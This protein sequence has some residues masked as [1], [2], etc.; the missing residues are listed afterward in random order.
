MPAQEK[1]RVLVADDITET[2]EN[3]KRLLQF[4]NLIEV[5]G[6]ARNGAEAIELSVQ[7]KPDVIIMDINMPDMDGISATEAIRK[8]VPYAQVIILSVQS[9]ASYMRR[10]ML[11]GA[12]DFLTKPPSIDELTAAIRRAG[13]VAAEERSKL[14]QTVSVAAT[15]TGGQS[16]SSFSNM[17]GKIIVVYSP[18]GGTGCTT[19]AT[20]LAMALQSDETPTNLLDASMQYGDVA[21]F[22]NEQV[23]NS[24]VDLLPRV[25]ELEPDV[26]RG[27]MIKHNATGLQVLAAPTRPE[28]AIGI[29]SEHFGKLINY[30]RQMYAYVIVDTSSYLTDVVQVAL[31]HANLV[32]LITTQDLPAIKNANT[33]LTLADAS[34]IKRNQIMFVMNRFDKRLGISP[35]RVSESLR[36]EIAVTIPFDDKIVNNSIIRGIPFVL[37][38]KAQPVARSIFTLADLLRERIQ[39]LDESTTAPSRK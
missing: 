38:N 6:G 20:N 33:F 24:L 23:K 10:A 39:K 30:L 11:A 34:G 32:V 14:S 35:E 16:M 36:Q 19:I 2:R 26:V 25:D 8:K 29:R 1:I 12:R 17:N 28:Q 5:V 31:E 9:D 37:D 27:V 15:P 18:K 13:V 3:I 21:V 7:Y 22:L 4:D